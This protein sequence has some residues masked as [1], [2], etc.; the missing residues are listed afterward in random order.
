MRVILFVLILIVL[1]FSCSFTG[2]HLKKP[3][4]VIY[5]SKDIKLTWDDFKGD[6]K[7][8]PQRSAAISDIKIDYA[9]FSSKSLDVR[10]KFNC[11]KSIKNS[12]LIDDEL[13]RHEQYHFNIGELFARKFRKKIQEKIEGGDT[14]S[15][16]I[17]NQMQKDFKS[18]QESYDEETQ[19]STN[20]EKQKEW[21]DKIDKELVVL[22]E[23][24]SK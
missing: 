20:V 2:K 6:I 19:H 18:Y 15:V 11:K 16:D 4:D 9:S 17:F 1:S 21:E 12:R 10:V 14:G 13:L 8:L 23:F 22:E 7:D 5:W 24:S 3:N